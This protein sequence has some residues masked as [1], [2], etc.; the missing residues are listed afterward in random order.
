MT[1]GSGDKVSITSLT[2]YSLT[3]SLELDELL[4]S[5]SIGEMGNLYINRECLPFFTFFTRVAAYASVINII[6]EYTRDNTDVGERLFLNYGRNMQQR[7]DNIY[8]IL[9]YSLIRP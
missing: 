5:Y 9:V 3:D 7:G 8:M 4:Y 2:L 1:G 6:P